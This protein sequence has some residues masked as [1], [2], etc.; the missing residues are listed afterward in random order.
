MKKLLTFLVALSILFSI[1]TSA[2]AVINVDGDEIFETS[3]TSDGDIGTA[4]VDNGETLTV[5]GNVTGNNNCASLIADNG[6]EIYVLDDGSGTKGN[7]TGIDVLCSGIVARN[8]SYVEI[9]GDVSAADSLEEVIWAQSGSTVTVGGDVTGANKCIVAAD[10]GTAVTVAGDVTLNPFVPDSGNVAVKAGNGVTVIIGGDVVYE[11]GTS[12]IAVTGSTVIIEGTAVG[13]IDSDGVTYI[14][15]HEGDI[16]NPENV[17]Y[18]I[19]AID[20]VEITGTVLGS[21]TVDGLSKTYLFTSSAGEVDLDGQKICIISK[22]SGTELSLAG[23]LP[24]GVSGGKEADGSIVLILNGSEFKG[25]LQTLDQIIELISNIV[26]PQ[27]GPNRPVVSAC[28]FT[29]IS[30][31]GNAVELAENNGHAGITIPAGT[32]DDVSGLTVLF[33][34]AELPAG[35][36]TVRE[37]SDGS[38]SVILGDSYLLSLGTGIYEF[39]VTF[40][41]EEIIVTV[42]VSK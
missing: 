12:V 30:I 2:F 38:L 42:Q 18:L 37:N 15:E 33:N 29:I 40:G 7:V 32:P 35:A 28:S 5:N 20:G 16:V 3:Y 22:D 4:N 24:E 34:G 8:S 31:E 1:E 25:G 14:G 41:G 36:F 17:C 23:S 39:I 19:A 21:G 6:A 27:P 10:Q 13:T 9:D 26:P 11:G